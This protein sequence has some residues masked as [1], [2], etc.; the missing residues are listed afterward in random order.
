MNVQVQ[1][2]N[3]INHILTET[4]RRKVESWEL[5]RAITRT[6]WLLLICI[7]NLSAAD[8]WSF[9]IS[10]DPNKHIFHMDA[11]VKGG[12]EWEGECLMESAAPPDSRR[13]LLCL[14]AV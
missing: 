5:H 4:L 10:Y 12:M 2:V 6:L 3:T 13:P 8:A 7:S 1:T 14:V 9:L 11:G